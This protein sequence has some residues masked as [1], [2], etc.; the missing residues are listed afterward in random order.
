MRFRIFFP[1]GDQHDATIYYMGIIEKALKKIS[2]DVRYIDNLNDLLCDDIVIVVNAKAHLQV[3]L[4]NRKQK[5]IC[6]YQGI[7]P[8]ELK[9]N[10]T[11]KDKWLKIILWTLFE[12]I[13]LTKVT[14]AL[15]VSERMKE[16]YLKK[17]NISLESNS[18]IM[19]CFNQELIENSFFTAGKYDIPTFVYAGTMS[20]WQ[21]VDEMLLLFKK[22]E[23]KIPDATLSIYTQDKE[24]AKSYIHKYKL[25][26]V[27]IDYLPYQELFH[28]IKKFKYGFLIRE[29]IEMNRVATPTKMNSYLANGIIPVY[30][31]CIYAFKNNLN[32]FPYQ[33]KVSSN[34]F[35]CI[36]EILKIEKLD[37]VPNV[38]LDSIRTIAFGSFYSKEFHIENLSKI[39]RNI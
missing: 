10:Y 32:D 8:E 9:V 7:M 16:H 26:N 17:Y 13:S 27:I 30:S 23:E 39:L 18:Y 37:I 22:I 1:K 5:V 36:D 21:C 28:A 2:D 15:F 4:K 34:Y 19:P 12:Y 24:I 14:F 20:K 25:N 38:I 3:L 35:D 31:D 6:W 33:V 11:R 29:D